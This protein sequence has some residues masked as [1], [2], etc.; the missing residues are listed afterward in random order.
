MDSFLT[1]LQ[2]AT[3]SWLERTQARFGE[4]MTSP[5]P[6]DREEDGSK[7]SPSPDYSATHWMRMINDAHLRIPGTRAA[8]LFRRRFRMPFPSFEKLLAICRQ[9]GWF[10][11][12]PVDVAGHPT[13]PLELKVLAVLR[14]F[15]RGCDFYDIQDWTNMDKK[16]TQTFILEFCQKFS[17]LHSTA[18][19]SSSL[20]PSP[21]TLPK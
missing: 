17:G 16:T 19:L 18:T 7:P 20:L 10:D 4:Q 14:M 12:G 21:T 1:K 15:G 2:V 9:P 3:T 5:K 13:A 8:K 11:Y 6:E